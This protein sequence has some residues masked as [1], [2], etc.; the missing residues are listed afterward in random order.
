MINFGLFNYLDDGCYS[1]TTEKIKNDMFLM[2]Q[3][4]AN[5]QI[6]LNRY[7][8]INFPET[9]NPDFFEMLLFLRGKAAF[10]NI[11]GKILSLGCAFG[12]DYTIYAD[13]NKVWVYSANGENIG[14]YSNYVVGS[15]NSNVD[16]VVCRDSYQCFPTF[17]YASICA[18]EQKKALMSASSVVDKMKYPWFISTDERSKTSTKNMM[19]DI[20]NGKDLIFYNKNGPDAIKVLNAGVDSTY[21]DKA[22]EAY[23][24]W[25]N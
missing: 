8:W 25:D 10:V 15:D 2:A 20:I 12:N 22:F 3:F 9:C 18:T 11:N 14:E 24:K 19:R 6:F 4:N 16:A 7:E 13:F 17:Y 5:S 21:V 23:S 1:G